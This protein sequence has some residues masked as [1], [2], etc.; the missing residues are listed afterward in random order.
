M[1]QFAPLVRQR[2]R[3]RLPGHFTDVM[4]FGDESGGTRSGT[5]FK[6]AF[7]VARESGFLIKPVTNATDVREAA[8]EWLLTDWV[9]QD[10]PSGEWVPRC[11]YGAYDCPILVQGMR[12]AYCLR[13]EGLGGAMEVQRPVKNF[14]SH[15]NDAHQYAAVRIRQMLAGR[16]LRVSDRRGA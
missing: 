7:E 12:G 8:V 9:S 2:L 13:S 14:W 15:V 1:A 11:V 5:D 16:E 6:S 3:A 4:H 10:G